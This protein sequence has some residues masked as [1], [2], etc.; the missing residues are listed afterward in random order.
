MM[1][2]INQTCLET[3]VI[4]LGEKEICYIFK[5]CCIISVLFSTKWR[6]FLDKVYDGDVQ[7]NAVL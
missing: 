5:T 2:Y 7:S 1:V 6:P 4:Y 3:D